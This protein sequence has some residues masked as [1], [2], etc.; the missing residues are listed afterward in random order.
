MC[1]PDALWR[2]AFRFLGESGVKAYEL[3]TLYTLPW[4][5]V[6]KIHLVLKLNSCCRNCKDQGGGKILLTFKNWGLNCSKLQQPNF[7]FTFQLTLNTSLEERFKGTV[8]QLLQLPKRF[9]Y[10]IL[11]LTCWKSKPQ[12]NYD[13]WRFSACK[14]R[15]LFLKCRHSILTMPANCSTFSNITKEALFHAYVRKTLKLCR[16][17][18]SNKVDWLV[19]QFWKRFVCS[20]RKWRKCLVALS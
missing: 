5:N 14:I 3:C 9:S 11:E 7:L 2:A 8:K 15:K 17:I 10:N 16:V 12:R 6:N 1:L 19:T 20:G 4:W 13:L 18:E